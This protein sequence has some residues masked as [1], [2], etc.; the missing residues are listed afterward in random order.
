MSWDSRM[1]DIR[2]G[3]FFYYGFSVANAASLDFNA[4]FIL[5]GLWDFL[6]YQF[7]ISTWLAN[8]NGPH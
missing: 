3:P 6:L 8:L 1:R 4:Y 2:K 5:L 7:E